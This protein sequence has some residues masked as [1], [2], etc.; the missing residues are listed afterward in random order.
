[1]RILTIIIVV[2]F[3]IIFLPLKLLLPRDLYECLEDRFIN[4]L[5]GQLVVLCFLHLFFDDFIEILSPFHGSTQYKIESSIT[6]NEE[7]RSPLF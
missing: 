3:T 7:I 6:K 5:I 4:T 2:I 1:M